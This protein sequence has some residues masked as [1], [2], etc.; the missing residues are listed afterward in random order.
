LRS[1]ADFAALRR[2]RRFSCGGLRFVYRV[3]DIG[4]ARLGMAVSRKYGN[5]VRRNRL[6]RQIREGFRQSRFRAISA[7]LLVTPV[8]DAKE[9]GDVQAVMDDALE[10]IAKKITGEE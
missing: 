3:T 10:R 9:M 4:H 5:A 8:V 7:D 6:K 1:K 2:G